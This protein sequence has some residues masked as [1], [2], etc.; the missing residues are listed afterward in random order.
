MSKQSKVGWALFCVVAAAPAQLIR[1]V[2][3]NP[4]PGVDFTSL[5]AAVA[6]SGPGDVLLVGPGTFQP[7]SVTGKDLH[8]FGAGPGVSVIAGGTTTAAAVLISNVPAGRKFDFAGFTISTIFVGSSSR[9]S[10]SIANG[11]VVLADI[12]VPTVLSG[13]FLTNDALSVSDAVV[14]AS[15]CSFS[16][17]VGSAFNFAV[18]GLYPPQLGGAGAVVSGAASAL[19]AHDCSFAGGALTGNV[20]LVAGPHVAGDGLRITGGSAELTQ[21]TLVGG[22][23]N[24]STYGGFLVNGVGGCA[25]SVAGT[26]FGRV[27]AS[28]VSG[29]NS[30]CSGTNTPGSGIEA[31]ATA[32]VLVHGA[33]AVTGGGGGPGAPAGLATVG[34][35][36]LG[37]PA[38]AAL[39]LAGT[40]VNGGELSATAPVTLT[41]DAPLPFAPFVVLLD[42]YPGLSFPFPSLL[43]NELVLGATWGIV[44][45]DFLDAAG[46]YALT[47]TPASVAPGATNA[48][49]H[50]QAFVADF[51]NAY[52]RGSN[53]EIRVFRN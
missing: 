44:F 22:S 2:A 1:T 37:L 53:Q 11:T 5:P 20:A 3:M 26:A 19:I 33:G 6:A 23:V 39:D 15:R 38:F 21:S 17:G 34:P 52:W 42:L 41:I 35:V 45:S 49:L 50:L 29:G 32:S 46:H 14:S 48:P 36:Q 47:F 18:F 40:N 43:M 7:F 28:T 27:D 9:K 31:A 8:I 51:A 10:L 12:V 4:G 13:L 24:L 30:T 16:G 25:L